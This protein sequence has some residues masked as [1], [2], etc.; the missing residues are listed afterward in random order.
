MKHTVM[1]FWKMIWDANVQS[2]LMILT[3][4]EWNYYGKNL[5]LLPDWQ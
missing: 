2:V 3:Q 5:R 1:D 4:S